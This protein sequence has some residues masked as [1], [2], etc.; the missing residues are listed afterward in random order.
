MESPHPADGLEDK[1]G[2]PEPEDH[3]SYLAVWLGARPDMSNRTEYLF[4]LALSGVFLLGMLAWLGYIYLE[5]V[6][7]RLYQV[8]FE[9]ER[10]RAVMN[11]ADS[12]GPILFIALQ[13]LQVVTIFW[14]VP[15]ELAGGFLF[16]W[17][18]GL[19]YSLLGLALGSMVAFLLGRWLE[20]RFVSRLVRPKTMKNIRQL[21]KREGTLAGFFIFLIPGIPKDFV[22]YF[23]G[24]T[25]ISLVFFLVAATLARIPG[26][27]LLTLQGA[28][29]YKGHYGI[30]LGLLAAYAGVV[31]LLYRYRESLYR[32][33][34][35]WH[36]EEE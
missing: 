6:R 15:L 34:G 22:C 9:R 1:A 25:R 21:L 35:Q 27:I 4:F 19:F 3:L 24:L 20:R 23:F 13:A 29:V 18:W 2:S 17:P 14:P 12:W 33:V 32:W 26:V 30:T 10:I 7:E 28:Q 11:G 5:P 31:V 16:G 36:Y 8:V